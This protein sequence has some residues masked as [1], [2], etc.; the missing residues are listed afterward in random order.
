MH[1]EL[2]AALTQI[3]IL[4]EVAKREAGLQAQTRSTLDL[5]SEAA[6]DV[7]TRMSHLVW[8][9]NPHNDTLD[10]LVAYLRE[11]AAA[12]LENTSIQPL[13]DFPAALPDCKVS[14]TFRRNL[15]LVLKEVLNNTIKHSRAS[16]LSF[17][18]SRTGDVLHL[19]IEDDGVG[20]DTT[21][22]RVRGNGLGN[23]QRRITD[24]GCSPR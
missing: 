23:I 10:N 3:T 2:G 18:L 5:I 1:D 4:G 21:R 22:A 16:R 14:A 12:Q 13:F 11:Q 7:T 24:L 17:K 15:L 8:A 6:R 9:T 20:F 19:Q